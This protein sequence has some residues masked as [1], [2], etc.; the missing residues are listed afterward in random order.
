MATT[1]NPTLRRLNDGKLALGFCVYHLRT[2]ASAMLAHATGYDWLFIDTEHGAFTTQETS[3]MCLAAI[4]FGITPIVRVCAD[5]L[6]E[7]TRALDNGAMGI[8]VPHV[9]TVASA[10]RAAMLRGL[11]KKGGR[12]K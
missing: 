9:S 1:A 6:D 4:P 2:V 12:T 10:K 5:A 8:I 7:A 3:R 11:E